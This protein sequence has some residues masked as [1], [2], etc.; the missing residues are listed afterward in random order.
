VAEFMGA[1]P[2]ATF[3]AV[4]VASSGVTADFALKIRRVSGGDGSATPAT[5]LTDMRQQQP[6]VYRWAR[7]HQY[8][9]LV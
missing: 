3:A 8:L 4:A 9:R 5:V 1:P 7:V 6:G 2:Q